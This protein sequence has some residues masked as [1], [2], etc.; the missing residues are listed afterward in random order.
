MGTS[1]AVAPFSMLADMTRDDSVP[2][3]LFNREKVGN[4]GSSKNDCIIL[5][6]CDAGVRKLAE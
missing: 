5:D 4:F 6:D 3:V 1:L 2:R